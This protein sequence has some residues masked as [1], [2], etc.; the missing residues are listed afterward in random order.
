[1]ALKIVDSYGEGNQDTD[2]NISAVI[3]NFGQSFTGNGSALNSVKLYL[4]KTGSPTGSAYIKIYAHS[5]I[6]GTSSVPT[7]ALLATSNAFDVSTLTTTYQLTEFTFSGT[8]RI[9]LTNSTYYCLVME[10]PYSGPFARVLFGADMSSPSHGGNSFYWDGDL[11]VWVADNGVDL[12]FYVYGVSP[13]PLPTHF[14][15]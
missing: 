3:Y 6:Y 2:K 12:C 9:V 7:G 5:G 13:S 10:I 15:L 11:G 4:K 14:N 8:E 1:M